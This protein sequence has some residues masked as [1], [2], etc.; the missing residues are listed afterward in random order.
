[1]LVVDDNQTNL[2]I[3]QEM[4]SNWGMLPTLADS[5]DLALEELRHGRERGE[6]FLLVVT[7]IN[8]PEMSGFEFVEGLRADPGL[9]DTQVIVLT[10]GGR[11]G[12]DRLCDRLRI[13]ERLMK[14][15]KQ[16]ELF[17]AIVRALGV[18]APEDA[19]DESGEDDDD[20]TLSKPLS[21][22]LAEDNVINQRL[23]VGVL[24][25]YGHQ[26][27][28]VGDG[29][30]A[31]DALEQ[32]DFDLVLMDVQM[33][34]MDGLEATRSIRE[35]EVLS[36]RHIPIIAMTA[37]AMKGDRE[38]CIEA[39]MDDYIPKPIHIA[40]LREILNLVHASEQS[41]GPDTATDANP[42]TAPDTGAP[43]NDATEDLPV[44]DE[45]ED[46]DELVSPIDWAR[47]RRTV[48]G[49][50][51]LLRE[52]LG[53]YQGEAHALMDQI[54]SALRDDDRKRL[55]HAAH[56][57]KGASLSVGAA[58][59]ARAAQRLEEI[60]DEHEPEVGRQAADQINHAIA[61]VRTCVRD[62]LQLQEGG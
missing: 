42:D 20:W 51:H 57:L 59:T 23:A 18:T 26:V 17:D 60:A 46:D 7:D 8:M 29:Q 48:G 45:S 37:H 30:Q 28:V 40:A 34:V 50:E 13:D 58:I 4:L 9:E 32:T 61:Q 11:D 25:K 14:P 36:G 41:G 56:T 3:L 22:L 62:Y 6:P 1:M 15:V 53:M 21:I 2:K 44:P 54:T 35:A 47:A 43:T 38:T 39:G 31:V 55:K 27:T 12:D 5:G 33:P 16:S 24:R 10:S 49:D 52:L 19:T